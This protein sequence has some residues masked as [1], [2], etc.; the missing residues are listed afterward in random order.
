[1]I[2]NAGREN[3]QERL[4]E[5][6]A[7]YTRLKERPG[8]IQV[9]LRDAEEDGDVGRADALEN[10]LAGFVG[11]EGAARIRLSVLTK[12][13]EKAEF[14]TKQSEANAA[15]AEGVRRHFE[16]QDRPLFSGTTKENLNN[17]RLIPQAP[18]YNADTGWKAHR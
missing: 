7:K 10:E 1:M 4:A 17:G 11:V 16:N 12:L 3:L 14:D 18:L 15:L 9:E 6:Q 5:A 2:E 13:A 8:E